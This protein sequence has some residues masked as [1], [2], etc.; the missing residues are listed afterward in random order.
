[1]GRNKFSFYRLANHLFIEIANSCIISRV[2]DWPA[3]TQLLPATWLEK[4][5]TRICLAIS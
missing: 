3:V 4:D 2:V 5:E 1:M